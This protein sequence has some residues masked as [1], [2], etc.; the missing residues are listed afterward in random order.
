MIALFALITRQSWR[1]GLDKVEPT[2]AV[3]AVALQMRD[4][5]GAAD[6]PLPVKAIQ[7]DQVIPKLPAKIPETPISLNYRG[8][9]LKSYHLKLSNLNSI[10]CSSLLV[11]SSYWDLK[12]ADNPN[13]LNPKGTTTIPN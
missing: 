13:S 11:L 10:G 9:T 7:L 4:E 1:P 2:K 12:K 8:Y 3:A 6:L 5:A